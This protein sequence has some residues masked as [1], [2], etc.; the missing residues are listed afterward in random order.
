[1]TI[2]T[3]QN[4]KRPRSEGYS[5]LLTYGSDPGDDIYL[6]LAPAAGGAIE[7]A[8]APPAEGG[9][10]LRQNPEDFRPESG[11]KFSRADF[12]GGEGLARAHRV[13]GGPLDGTRFWASENVRVI[14]PKPGE[15]PRFLLA[16]DQEGVPNADAAATPYPV[17]LANGTRVFWADGVE[18]KWSNDLMAVSPSITAEN[19][20]TLAGSSSR[21]VTG[22]GLDGRTLY[23]AM[24]GIEGIHQRLWNGGSGTWSDWSDLA[25][26]SLWVVKRRVIAAD[27]ND[28]Y[29]AAAGAGSVLLKSLANDDTWLDVID[30]G[31]LI[32]AAASDGKI[33]AFSDEAGSLILRGET[34]L[35]PGEKPT[36]LG[37]ADGLVFVGVA[38]ENQAGG[39]VGR[40]Y[41][42]QMA[43]VRLRGGRLIREWGDEAS[44]DDH[45]PY[46][47]IATRDEIMCTVIDGDGNT[48]V[49]SYLLATA[50]T[51]KRLTSTLTSRADLV[52]VDNSL[53]VFPLGAAPR[54]E[55]ND[56][57]AATGYIIFP[58]ADWYNA[59]QKAVVGVRIES[60][61]LVAA[62]EQ[63][64]FYYSTD[65]A[66]LDDDSHAS[67]TLAKSLTFTGDL[68]EPDEIPLLEV[69]G[70]GV[71]LMVKLTRATARTS[72]PEVYSVSV[73]AFEDLEDVLIS[74]PVNVS[75]LL[76]RPGKHAVRVKGRG[77]ALYAALRG[78]EG[79]PA[80]LEI[81]RTGEKVKGRV[82]SV[83]V[84]MPVLAYRGSSMLSCKVVVRGVPV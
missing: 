76:E 58:F 2:P 35:R 15:K 72:S 6:Q 46:G 16:W 13:D 79:G 64:D 9:P 81:L 37:F 74:V 56:E 48:A 84:P 54:R 42:H 77:E 62:G 23:A 39:A 71:A 12:S 22:L 14:V 25:A 21:T 82:E 68:S 20:G 75:D 28:L 67:W 8:T 34:P 7:R 63:I 60:P 17:K 29:D 49:W 44:T 59:A 26:D 73:R 11:R 27:G 51:Y 43:G 69:S 1:M 57:Y 10:N 4:V 40:L 33:Y 24:D 80:Q 18:V 47:F 5:A 70:R 3:T 50:G 45:S 52:M 30:A 83:S 31:H 38:D 32:L 53:I 78:R 65:P 61:D 41:V 55:E 19:P 66:A 36:A